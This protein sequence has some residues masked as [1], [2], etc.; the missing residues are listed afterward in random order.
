[1]PR[2][3][4]EGGETAPF[5]ASNS[6]RFFAASGSPATLAGAAALRIAIVPQGDDS[7][8]LTLAAALFALPE[9]LHDKD[10]RIVR[11]RC[12]LYGG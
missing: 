5:G 1:M 2:C 12:A 7:A 6:F 9:M 3:S 11:R 4:A 10:S 8:A